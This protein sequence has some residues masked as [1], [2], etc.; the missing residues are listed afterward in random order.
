MDYIYWQWIFLDNIYTNPWF[1][2]NIFC[3]KMMWFQLWLGYLRNEADILCVWTNQDSFL[4]N[5]FFG[6]I[7]PKQNT[8]VVYPCDINNAVTGNIFPLEMTLAI[9]WGNCFRSVTSIVSRRKKEREKVIRE[10][11]LRRERER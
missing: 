11:D 10:R 2:S 6:D 5:D 3:Y 4:V 8:I 9:H 7:T 1:F